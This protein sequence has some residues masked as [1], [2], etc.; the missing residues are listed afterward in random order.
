VS[1]TEIEGGLG[2]RGGISG[3]EKT[4][5]RAKRS[6]ACE[7][8]PMPRALLV[9]DSLSARTVLAARLRE[10]GFEVEEAADGVTGAE[11]ALA[12]PP[13]IVM[14]DLWMPG[15]SGV[16]LCRLLRSEPR[17]RDVPVV[18]IT[19]ESSRRSRFWART[20]GA[21]A[22]LVKGDSASLAEALD[23][24]GPFESKEPS[25]PPSGS[26]RGTIHERLSQR[27]DAALFE[28]VVSGEVRGLAQS[29]GDAERLFRGL[30]KL[31]SDIASYRWIALHVPVSAGSPRE[32]R[33]GRLFLHC[34]PQTREAC[35][36][37]ARTTL[38]L[39]AETDLLPLL[40]ERPLVARSS[41]P[42]VAP[43][44]L[45]SA[46]LGTL[47]FAPGER[48]ASNED[49][50]L[51]S[52]VATELGGPLRIVSLVEEARQL[53]MSDPL[54]GLMNRRAFVEAMGRELSRANRYGLPLSMLLL[55]V[56][57]F[58]KVNDTRGHEAGDLVLKGVSATVHSIARKSDIVGRW[59]GEEFVL[60][61]PQATAAGARVAAE[62]LRRAVADASFALPDGP[63]L[64]VTVSIGVAHGVK[65]E[66]LETI[67]ARADEA[68]YL[69]KSRGRNRVET[70]ESSPP[71]E[72][73]DT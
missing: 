31:A 16:Q 67:V 2:E 61:L 26:L 29:D 72:P 28:S 57:H 38:R 42:L 6:E 73:R 66:P 24:L 3:H 46:L 17:T 5:Y 45:G 21:A 27:L 44:H 50:Q 10:R 36:A 59:G 15:L 8:L 68:M 49:R 32:S 35:E 7:D 54:T 1:G 53:A 22:Y 65:G 58:K 23:I 52:I 43:I 34:H 70:E 62:R 30:V 4:L 56:D 69:A 11:L 20:A 18:L 40:D 48:G 33:V 51:V 37:E 41:L 47:L 14:T 9:D 64:R 71:T 19:S 63:A 39:P 25:P 60:G 55:D 13:D 12:H